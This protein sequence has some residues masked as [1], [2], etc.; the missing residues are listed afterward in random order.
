MQEKR[1]Q[2]YREHPRL[3]VGFQ[4]VHIRGKSDCEFLFSSRL[5]YSR[6]RRIREFRFGLLFSI[7]LFVF[8]FIRNVNRNNIHRIVVVDVAVDLGRFASLN[9]L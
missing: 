9:K 3:R 2:H 6:R 4:V 7:R 5:H 8:L 1:Q